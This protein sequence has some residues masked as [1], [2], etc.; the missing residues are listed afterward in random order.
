MFNVHNAPMRGILSVL[1]PS[2]ELLETLPV[3]RMKEG[4]RIEEIMKYETNHC[5]YEWELILL[6]IGCLKI[7]T[8]VRWTDD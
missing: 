1:D 7:S 8:D 6:E 4:G 5:Q 2:Y 3:K